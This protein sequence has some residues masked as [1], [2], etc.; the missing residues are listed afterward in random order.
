MTSKYGK[1]SIEA[2]RAH[3]KDKLKRLDENREYRGIEDE[4]V[5]FQ[6]FEDQLH[7]EWLDDDANRYSEEEVVYLYLSS[8]ARDTTRWPNPG[9]YMI[10]LDSEIDNIIKADLIQFSFPLTDPTVNTTNQIIRY[11]FAPHTTVNSV[12]IPIGSYKGDELALE[13][14]KQ[15]NMSYHNADILAGTYFIDETT[16]YVVDGSGNL[17]A[18]PYPQ[19]RVTYQRPAHKFYFTLV[20]ASKYPLA[21]PVWALHIQPTPSTGQ[22]SFRNLTD[23][24]WGVLGFSRTKAAEVGTYDAGS[25]TYYLVSTTAYDDFG[26]ANDVDK[27][28]AYSLHSSRV[29]EMRGGQ[30]IV[31]D[32]E[33]LNDNDIGHVTDAPSQGFDVGRCFGMVLARDAAQVADRM[34]D[35]SNGNYP[36]QKY[37]RDGRSRIK[38]IMVT[39]RRLDGSVF[40][41]GGA[42]HFMALRFTTKRTQPKKSVF[43]R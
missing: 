34:L 5:R 32:I 8:V 40:D 21:S 37:Y 10:Q 36:V 27:R 23:D 13:V 6:N 38:Q 16:G 4:D 11:S 41:F 26:P 39:L 12:T 9:Q 28:I 20:N 3:L 25:D 42:D 7:L 22:I 17:P 33:P 24:L 19:F 29:A 18:D 43:A 30:I 15:M 35:V 14:M 31:L 1:D 2:M